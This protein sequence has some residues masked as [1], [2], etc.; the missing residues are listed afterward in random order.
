MTD[1]PLWADL[2]NHNGVGYGHGSLDRSYEIARGA[3]LDA[4]CFTPHGFWHDRPE[5]DPRMQ[6]FHEKGFD[7]VRRSWGEIV[8]KANA[9]NTDG[10]LTAFIGF[11]WHSSEFGDY[12]V[13]FPGEAGELLEP[14]SAA[15][16]R[17]FCRE[18]GALM[19]PHHVAYQQGWRGANWAEVD[20]KLSPVVEVFSEHGCGMEPESPWPM[21]G[22]SMGGSERSQTFIE[23]LKRGRVAGVVASTDNHWG[24][25]ASYGEGLTGI[26]ADG[27]DRAGIVDAIRK[28][29]TVA[30]TGDRIGLNVTLGDGRMGD[31]LPADAPRTLRA[32]ID[33]LGAVDFVQIIKNGRVVH[34]RPGPPRVVTHETCPDDT[35]YVV[36]LEF[37]WDAMMSEAA[38]DW[39]V[40]AWVKGG[41]I[42]SM[43][44]CFAGGAS[45][46]EKLN[47][48]LSVAPE[49]VTF[50]AFT[51]RLNARP[52]SAVVLRLEGGPDTSI[53]VAVAAEHEGAECGCDLSATL[54]QLLARDAWGAVSPVFSAPKIRL[55]NCH[56]ES[57]LRFR[58]DWTDPQPGE[59]DWYLVK[60]QQK[61]GH[62]AWSSPIWCR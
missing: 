24:H 61:N 20:P 13:L 21:L 29:R 34:G 4:Y 15:E 35:V 30:V 37:G 19:I 44:P 16:L 36:R 56:H 7:L 38:T 40:R 39:H 33:A 12:H 48:V 28:R 9:E 62:A 2:H 25:P 55:G 14:R 47:R 8:D 17:D 53:E 1:R 58:V 42:V 57:E 54:G 10:E 60:V 5:S 22:H 18:H 26:W 11:E 59:N 50:E 32:E 23:E 41:Q 49:E 45:S 46:T 51:S 31:V 6:A 27:G 43:A 3:L 52:T